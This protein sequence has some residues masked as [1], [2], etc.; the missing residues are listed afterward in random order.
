MIVGIIGG[1]GK[2]GTFFKGVFEKAGYTTLV[3]GRK[4]ILTNHNVAARADLII[5]SVPIHAT[6]EVI[7]EIAPLLTERHVICDLTSLKVM[8]I[9]AML[10]SRA[11]V[12]GL[13]PMFGPTVTSLTGQTIVA[14]PAR[15]DEATLDRVLSIFINQGARIVTTTPE[16]HDRIMAIVQGLTHFS[17][18]CMAETMRLLDVDIARALNFTSPIYRIEMD[19]IG[20]LLSQDPDLYGGI[21]QMNPSVPAVIAAFHEAVERLSEITKG[22][23]RD[24]F[25]TFFDKNVAKFSAYSDEAHEETD[26]LIEFMVRR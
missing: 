4:T 12:L 11:Q 21:L 1:T 3:S 6:V 25:T 26:A 9:E 8:P 10:R 5:V 18:L 22:K 7:N 19:L 24:H 20:R 2:M 17:T 14:T 23:Q 16:E 13:H 15:V